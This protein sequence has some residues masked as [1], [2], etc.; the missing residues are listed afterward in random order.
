MLRR[1]GFS[2]ARAHEALSQ[3]TAPDLEECLG[4]LFANV[5]EE[6]LNEAL[7]GRPSTSQRDVQVGES[8]GEEDDEDDPIAPPKLDAYEYENYEASSR[9]Q[10]SGAV[11]PNVLTTASASASESATPSVTGLSPAPRSP[12]SELTNGT[13]SSSAASPNNGAEGGADSDADLKARILAL[14]TRSRSPSPDLALEDPNG[15][16]ARARLRIVEI[17]QTRSRRR[18]DEKKMGLPADETIEEQ[19]DSETTRCRERMVEAENQRDF[20]KDEAGKRELCPSER[21]ARN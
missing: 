11:T 4:W 17:E 5:P 7:S 6:E 21:V 15:T 1:V 9:P 19:E 3:A 8:E 2:R 10:G 20:D 13:S 18:K 14:S 16:W 12:P